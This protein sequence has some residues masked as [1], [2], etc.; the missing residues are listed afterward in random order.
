M[1]TT[2]NTIHLML[3]DGDGNLTPGPDAEIDL[4]GGPAWI[5]LGVFNP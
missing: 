5:A 2:D 3:G 4:G 1:T